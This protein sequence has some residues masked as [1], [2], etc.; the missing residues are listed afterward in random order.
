MRFRIAQMEAV[1]GRGVR[2]GVEETEDVLCSLDLVMLGDA[3][4]RQPCPVV[5]MVTT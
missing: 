1:T 4:H 3:R 5:D 2:S